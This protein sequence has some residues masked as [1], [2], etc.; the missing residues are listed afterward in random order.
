ML[1]NKFVFFTKIMLLFFGIYCSFV[2]GANACTA[3]INP[4]MEASHIKRA[5]LKRD[6][7]LSGCAENAPEKGLP[8]IFAFHGG[9]EVIHKK[10]KS[11]FL[12][13][14][15]L[16]KAGALV[17]AP[18]GNHSHNGHSWINAFT[19]LK[20]NPENDLKLAL[21]IKEDLKSRNDL[22][23]IDFSRVY[24]LGKSDGAGMAMF[25]ACH[26]SKVISLKAAALVSGAYFGLDSAE[27][28]GTGQSQICAPHHPTKMI[29]IHGTKDQVMPYHGQNFINPKALKHAKDHWILKDESVNP[30]GSNT[31]SANVERYTEFLAKKINKC[32]NKK[33]SKISEVSELIKWENCAEELTHIRVRGGNHVWTGHKH[34][35]PDSGKAPNMDFDATEKV[36]SFFDIAM[37]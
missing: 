17:V 11:G 2:G 5:D 31:Y 27:N 10:N 6:F 21:A 35:G 16:A 4:K 8:I 32:Q 33:S 19:W 26:G 3:P 9:G 25:L 37:H 1:E 36:L 28:F 24:A 7:Y 14:T 34:S 22:P 20:E 29:F 12:D 30:K 15:S 13:F 18:V 23:K